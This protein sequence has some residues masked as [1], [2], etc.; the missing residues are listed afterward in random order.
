MRRRRT[1]EQW[2]R[3]FVEFDRSGQTQERFCAKRRVA[4]ATF[5][6]WRRKLRATD[7]AP[8]GEVSGFVEVCLPGMPQPAAAVSSQ[9]EPDLVVELPYGVVL[10]FRGVQAR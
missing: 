9:I 2:R 6:A 4:L 10:K 1:A 3:L 8:V 5:A 7:L